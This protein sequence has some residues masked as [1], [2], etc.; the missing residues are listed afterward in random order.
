MQIVTASRTMANAKP[1]FRNEEYW[2]EVLEQ[3][4]EIIT[5]LKGEIGR[6]KLKLSHQAEDYEL[7]LAELKLQYYGR[8]SL[9]TSYAAIEKRICRV[10]AISKAELRGPGRERHL[11]LARQCTL[12][13]ARRRLGLSYPALG[14]HCGDRD[15]T[16][17]I[18]AVTEYPK[19]RR[20]MGRNI[21][22]NVTIRARKLRKA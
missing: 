8:R 9:G 14:R 18:H 16:S 22:A 5:E 3:K 20:K 17:I 19:K 1:R 10:F 21:E 4:E 7:A 6:L 15:H 11:V 12:Y 2:S 13:W